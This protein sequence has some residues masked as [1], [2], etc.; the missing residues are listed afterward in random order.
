MPDDTLIVVSA[1]TAAFVIFMVVLF[2]ADLS[3]K[4]PAEKRSR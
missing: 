2:W 4:A 1:V 3:Q